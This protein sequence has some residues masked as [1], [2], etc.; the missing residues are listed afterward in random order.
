[1]PTK[2][3]TFNKQL[4]E[5]WQRDKSINP[6]TK[7]RITT[8]GI[9]YRAVDKAYQIYTVITKSISPIPPKTKSPLQMSKTLN[10]TSY[11]GR[12]PTPTKPKKSVKFAKS[13]SP[14]SRAFESRNSNTSS[15]MSSPVV[16]D[17]KTAFIGDI[18]E[19]WTQ[20]F[21]KVCPIDMTYVKVLNDQIV[22]QIYNAIDFKGGGGLRDSTVANNLK[23]LLN[24]YDGSEELIDEAHKLRKGKPV[25]WFIKPSTLGPV[26]RHML[27][28]STR[29]E[30]VNDNQLVDVCVCLYECVFNAVDAYTSAD[31]K[32]EELR[33]VRFYFDTEEPGFT[34][35]DHKIIKKGFS[36]EIKKLWNNQF[37]RYIKLLPEALPKINNAIMTMLTKKAEQVVINNN[38]KEFIKDLP[39]SSDTRRTIADVR[40]HMNVYTTL[41]KSTYAFN[42]DKLSLVLK[43]LLPH[44]YQLV[45]DKVRIRL[46]VALFESTFDLLEV[47]TDPKTSDDKRAQTWNFDQWYTK[48]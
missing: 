11:K 25:W 46:L 40:E 5:Q 19:L 2:K 41:E 10:K 32:S 12:T 37:E 31:N 45:N 16:V 48:P 34:D 22:I 35:E 47:Y 7:R 24:Y 1:M 44:H 38:G 15:S 39:E 17:L 36:D 18:I 30:T 13:K 20:D 14:P 6:F 33:N 29:R 23:N 8:N 27:A 26:I 21:L 9:V 43:S 4:C 42:M 3:Y 28:T